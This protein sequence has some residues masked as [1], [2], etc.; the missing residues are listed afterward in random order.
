MAT[1]PSSC[2]WHEFGPA[3]CN[4]R[5]TSIDDKSPLTEARWIRCQEQYCFRDFRRRRKPLE[6]MQALYE[7]AEPYK[8]G[9]REVFILLIL[10]EPNATA[11][12]QALTILAQTL[13][14]IGSV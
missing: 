11:T 1:K 4:V 10:P 9:P 12:M 2:T 8:S 6:G 3:R 13:A 7:G 14:R 5:N